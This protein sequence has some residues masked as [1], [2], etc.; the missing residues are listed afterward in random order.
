MK[1]LICGLNTKEKVESTKSTIF[2]IT[3]PGI[4]I[5][6][7]PFLELVIIPELYAISFGGSESISG[8]SGHLDLSFLFTDGIFNVTKD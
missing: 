4:V 7:E 5:I 1:G 6:Q 3:A 2:S 8:I